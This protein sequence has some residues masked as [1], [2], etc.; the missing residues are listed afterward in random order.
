[1]TLQV[2]RGA[3]ALTADLVSFTHLNEYV[4]E[5]LLAVV[6]RIR[7]SLVKSANFYDPEW[8]ATNFGEPKNGAAFRR[9][10]AYIQAKLK[11][12]NEK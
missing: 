7:E 6:K 5:Q 11:L 9:W 1:M 8:L 12:K 3:S 2:K 10:R 4:E